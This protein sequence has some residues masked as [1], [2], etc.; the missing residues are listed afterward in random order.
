MT[1]ALFPGSLDEFKDMYTT[2]LFTLKTPIG[3][4]QATISENRIRYYSHTCAMINSAFTHLRLPGQ[5][6][7][8]KEYFPSPWELPEVE[9]C[10]GSTIKTT[11][12]LLNDSRSTTP[13]LK[14][15]KRMGEDYELVK[16]AIT[17]QY[18][19]FRHGIILDGRIME[20]LV[21]VVL[22]L[23]E[24]L[25]KATEVRMEDGSRLRPGIIQLCRWRNHTLAATLL[26]TR[27][28]TSS[29][30]Q[31]EK[32]PTIFKITRA[33]DQN[34]ASEGISEHTPKKRRLSRRLAK[35]SP[36]LPSLR[37]PKNIPGI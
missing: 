8:N 1:P 35:Q 27:P 2:P 16:T 18:K 5:H 6:Q 25:L 17:Q 33:R 13:C 3:Q 9:V 37:D 20:K 19:R 34:L 10:N 24:P 7:G 15:V 23:Y 21:L 14:I 30:P 22:V 36:E 12:A 32:D 29:V 4:N 28:T 11:L 26:M 31:H